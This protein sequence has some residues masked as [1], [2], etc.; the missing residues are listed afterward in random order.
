MV[1]TFEVCSIIFYYYYSCMEHSHLKY[2]H[3]S[4]TEMKTN[5]LGFNR[6]LQLFLFHMCDFEDRALEHI[7]GLCPQTHMMRAVFAV[8]YL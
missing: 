6:N 8:Y 4:N 7:C 3:M 2:I 1:A 5:I